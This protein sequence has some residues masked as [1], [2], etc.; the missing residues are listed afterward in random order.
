VNREKAIRLVQS[1]SGE[2]DVG[3]VD[4]MPPV[5]HYDGRELTPARMIRIRQ[6]FL[7]EMREF[8]GEWWM[9]EMHDGELFVWGSYESLDEAAAA[10]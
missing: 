2:D 10:H 5:A 4:D 7:V 9:G 3:F 8:Q 1:V 6:R